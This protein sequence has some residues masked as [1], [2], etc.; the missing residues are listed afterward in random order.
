M[1]TRNECNDLV[2]RPGK[3]EGEPVYAPYYYDIMLNGGADEV[4]EDNVDTFTVTEEDRLIFPELKGIDTII[5]YEDDNG[6]I[7]T[8]QQ[9]TP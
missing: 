2:N 6:F 9:I 1:M 7:Y 4:G 8:S 3:F 5:Q